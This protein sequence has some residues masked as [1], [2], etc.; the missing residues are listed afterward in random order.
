MDSVQMRRSASKKKSGQ[1]AESVTTDLF[2]SGFSSY[3]FPDS[4]TNSV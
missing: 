4:S 3:F 1:S 2:R